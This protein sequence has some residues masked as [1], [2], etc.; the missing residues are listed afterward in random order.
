MSLGP[1]Q[2]LKR[3]ITI[4]KKIRANEEDMTSC[5]DIQWQNKQLDASLFRVLPPRM[6]FRLDRSLLTRIYAIENQRRSFADEGKKRGTSRAPDQ[7][8][9]GAV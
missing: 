1:K 9:F 2:S 6:L 5:G 8:N 7:V 3:N 4:Y